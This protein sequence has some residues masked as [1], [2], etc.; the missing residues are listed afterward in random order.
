MQS[1]TNDLQ[2]FRQQVDL[3]LDKA[4]NTEDERALLDRVNHDPNYSRVLSKEQNF[5]KFIKQNVKR[6]EA[7]PDFIQAI[8]NKIRID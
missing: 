7:S 6:A 8:K 2:D 1:R 5:R 4:L 3:Y